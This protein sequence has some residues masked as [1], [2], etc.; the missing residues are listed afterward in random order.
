MARISSASAV[1]LLVVEAGCRLVEQ[2][3]LRLDRERPGKLDPL[4][5]AERQFADRAVGDG[6]EVELLDQRVGALGYAGALPVAAKGSASA[7]V[8]K[9]PRASACAPTRTLSRVDMVEK[10]ATF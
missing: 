4:A 5:D 6:L 8:R 2:K 1:D 3:E 10:S 7:F 9:P